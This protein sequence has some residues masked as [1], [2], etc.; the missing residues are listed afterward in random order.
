[1]RQ[2][3]AADNRCM[4]EDWYGDEFRGNFITD[5]LIP[6]AFACIPVAALLY[7]LVMWLKPR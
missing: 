5:N 6:F 3:R 1:M 4:K 2:P 7:S